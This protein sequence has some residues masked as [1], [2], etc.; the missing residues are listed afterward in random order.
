MMAVHAFDDIRNCLP[1]LLLSPSSPL[2]EPKTTPDGYAFLAPSTASPTNLIRRIEQI[3]NVEIPLVRRGG[4]GETEEGIAWNWKVLGG[5]WAWEVEFGGPVMEAEESF[6]SSQGRVEGVEEM[7]EEDAWFKS[8]DEKVKRLEDMVQQARLWL[9]DREEEE[10]STPSRREQ[11]RE[12]EEL[13][14]ATPYRGEAARRQPASYRATPTPQ[15][16]DPAPQPS[17]NSSS[18]L[19]P[20][21]AQNYTILAPSIQE[22]ITPVIHPPP[23]PTPPV[24][25]VPRPQ[26]ALNYAPRQQQ[27]EEPSFRSMITP[28][29][30]QPRPPPAPTPP[31]SI[32]Q[33]RQPYT[34]SEIS[35]QDESIRPIPFAA[36]SLAPMP[37][38]T[39]SPQRRSPETSFHSPSRA[40]GDS[41]ARRPA[42][43]SPSAPHSSPRPQPQVEQ[44]GY[45]TCSSGVTLTEELHNHTSYFHPDTN[46]QPA[47]TARDDDDWDIGS[48]DEI[49]GFPPP[50]RGE[51]GEEE[52]SRWMAVDPHND[53][54]ASSE[55]EVLSIPSSAEVEAPQPSPERQNPIQ[56]V[57]SSPS[58]VSPARNTPLGPGLVPNATSTPAA[59]RGDQS[60][61][62]APNATS[63]PTQP[64]YSSLT[65]TP[66]PPPAP[67]PPKDVLP[68][69]SPSPSFNFDTFPELPS[70][71]HLP[72]RRPSQ[73]DE[74]LLNSLSYLESPL[75]GVY[76]ESFDYPP[77][78]PPVGILSVIHE[79]DEPTDSFAERRL[80]RTP[81]SRKS[82][83]ANRSGVE[84]EGLSKSTPVPSSGALGDRPSPLST[85]TP[86]ID[87]VQFDTPTQ[88]EEEQ[89]RRSSTAGLEDEE[90]S[91]AMFM[92]SI[93][94]PTPTPSRIIL[95]RSKRSREK[96]RRLVPVGVS[97]P[98]TPQNMNRLQDG[99]VVG[100][101]QDQ[102]EEAVPEGRREVSR[103]PEERLQEFTEDP[104]AGE[105][106]EDLWEEQALALSP[107]SARHEFSPSKVLSTST[108]KVANSSASADKSPSKEEKK[109][110][111]RTRSESPEKKEK[112][113]KDRSRSRSPE[114]GK[115]GKAHSERS[116]R[117][118]RSEK[119]EKKEDRPKKEA[120]SRRSWFGL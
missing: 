83:P 72:V 80:R 13:K 119:K 52:Y 100:E 66:Q 14:N 51:D 60:I 1:P 73:E 33:P 90:A 109:G 88:P 79:V 104:L 113:K 24:N 77:N 9:E 70:P 84:E 81:G 12:F 30:Q 35:F 107:T 103:S 115:K 21:D 114:K 96:A 61:L 7:A 105:E 2:L 16:E 3:G 95:N 67:S 29:Q 55:F 86:A 27:M 112:E 38:L 99:G 59:P 98:G 48:D 74:D 82:T 108:P 19:T 10:E 111:V 22:F 26:E 8:V 15:A 47:T 44:D 5:W 68:D 71:E 39:R 85:S 46:W 53:G 89:G 49:T 75:G 45:S 37:I 110:K 50:R 87:S 118:E 101:S 57:Y 62:L 91:N 40:A 20:E 78:P 102:Q 64:S 17:F 41:T 18:T 117:S 63:T 94:P 65:Q 25:S 93:T 6:R 76:E 42:R 69:R 116:E 28:T 120:P 11:N 56:G 43:Q 92:G 106:F 31:T 36:P 54:D 32:P 4:W 34:I 23:A 97:A 58:L